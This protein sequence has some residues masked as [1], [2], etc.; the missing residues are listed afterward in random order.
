[1]RQVQAIFLAATALALA[2]CQLSA[3]DMNA[4]PNGAAPAPVTGRA[5]GQPYWGRWEAKNDPIALGNKVI[6]DLLTRDFP[7]SYIQRGGMDYREVCTAYG[8]VRLAGTLG[9]AERLA[10]LIKRYEIF[11]TPAGR[12]YVPPANNV[13][14]SVFG[15]LPMEIYRRNGAKEADQRWLD[16]GKN[17]ADVEWQQLGTDGLT[18]FNRYWVD[19]MF[20][21]TA[22]Q[23]EAY[24]VTQ[25]KKYLDRDAKEVVAYLKALQQPNG[26]FFHAA[27]SPY[28]WGRGNGWV[29]VGMAEILSIL[30]ADHP[31]RA[32]LVAGYKKM[33]AGLLKCQAKNGM[34]RQL[35]DIDDPANWDETSGTG[36]I[37]FSMAMGVRHGWLD[38]AT[39]KEPVK[40][41]WLEFSTHINP[42]GKVRDVCVGTN[43]AAQ[44]ILTGPGPQMLQYYLTRQK[45]VGD[46]H[47]Q[48][49]FIWAA[50][51]MA[52]E[53]GK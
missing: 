29:A 26:L 41:A 16:L 21:V 17:S 48:A 34:W 51:A 3:V 7:Q 32:A 5:T 46:F 20:M 50:Y 38:E 53:P 18:S 28:C 49:G 37:I 31:E 43:K 52:M 39:Y 9:D 25:D 14:N 23:A 13:D 35:L 10:K 6:D 22:L 12:V 44:T 42:D 15:I 30:P 19:D 36:M 8:S 24:R 33:M 27:D 47:G 11:F 4:T 1:V 45:A 40:K 2:A